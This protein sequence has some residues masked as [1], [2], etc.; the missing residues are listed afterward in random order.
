MLSNGFSPQYSQT[1]VIKRENYNFSLYAT[2]PDHYV[3]VARRDS[4]YPE[5]QR[6]ESRPAYSIYNTTTASS[7]AS[8]MPQKR[9]SPSDG[10]G[11]GN[12]N[13]NTNASPAKHVKTE[14]PEEFSNTVK[15][16]LAS[17]TR[18]GQACDR[19]KVFPNPRPELCYGCMHQLMHP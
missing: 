7:V 16:R 13:V 17:S 3:G 1:P 18:T 8:M 12:G 2:P 10:N 15:K 19:C 4:Q 6:R 11:N 14:H 9:P 5:S